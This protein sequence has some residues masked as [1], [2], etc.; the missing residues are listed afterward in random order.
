MPDGAKFVHSD[1]YTLWPVV[2]GVLL[3]WRGD[4]LGW[5]NKQSGLKTVRSRKT[6]M[7]GYEGLKMC[8][9]I[10]SSGELIRLVRP[11]LNGSSAS[12]RLGSRF[13][14]DVRAVRAGE[15]K[16]R[17][18]MTIVGLIVAPSGCEC[19][20][21]VCALLFASFMLLFVWF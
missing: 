9:K 12:I 6:V 15:A 13:V 11:P 14:C 10:R 1:I 5:D 20:R 4:W 7:R 3:R 2:G 21:L 16:L 17:W 18:H 19:S 8:W